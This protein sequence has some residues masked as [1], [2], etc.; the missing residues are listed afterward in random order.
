MKLARY[1]TFSFFFGSSF[2]SVLTTSNTLR[3]VWCADLLPD[4][5]AAMPSQQ[6]ATWCAARSNGRAVVART[7]ACQTLESVE[8]AIAPERN[9][10]VRR[11]QLES[12]D[13]PSPLERSE[14]GVVGIEGTITPE[15]G[16]PLQGRPQ[17]CQ[18][19][20]KRWEPRVAISDNTLQRR[21]NTLFAALAEV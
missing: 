19:L 21:A 17:G 15:I 11:Q 18:G 20:A 1:T 10:I 2:P 4:T 5:A 3:R 6:A 16:L 9:R 13:A 12:A 14:D 8:H 7:Q